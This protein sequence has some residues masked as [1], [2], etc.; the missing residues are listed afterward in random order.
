[1]GVKF[2]L[3]QG[4]IVHFVLLIVLATDLLVTNAG[5]QYLWT[6]KP[7][8]IFKS[9]LKPNS[10]YKIKPIHESKECT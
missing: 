6:G 10:E 5:L 3:L 8:E 9:S 7:S 4:V 2:P 1:M